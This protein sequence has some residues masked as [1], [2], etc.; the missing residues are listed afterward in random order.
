MFHTEQVHHSRRHKFHPRHL[1]E[2]ERVA[3]RHDQEVARASSRGEHGMHLLGE[4]GRW[5]SHRRPRAIHTLPLA[6]KISPHA[7]GHHGSP[8]A[9]GVHPPKAMRAAGYTVHAGVITPPTQVSLLGDDNFLGKSWLKKL[10]KKVT[11]FIP[12]PLKKI[13]SFVN[14]L[15]SPLSPIGLMS[16]MV[17]KEKKTAK[18]KAAKKAAAAAYNAPY[19]AIE[20]AK[21]AQLEQIKQ[22]QAQGASDAAVLA[23]QHQAQVDAQAAID[24]QTQADAQAQQQADFL[25]QQQQAALQAQQTTVSTPEAPYIP[26]APTPT[27]LPPSTASMYAPS[28]MAPAMQYGPQAQLPPMQQTYASQAPMATEEGGEGYAPPPQQVYDEI[29]QQMP[30]E[31]PGEEQQ[32]TEFPSEEESSDIMS[33]EDLTPEEGQIE[34]LGA[35]SPGVMTPLLLVGVGVA[36]YYFLGK[37]RR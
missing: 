33:T 26:Y 35:I 27:M 25:R 3:R 7:R 20:A 15:K 24:A 16:T 2:A 1:T 14:P 11:S 17:T 30:S 5:G 13:I 10:R 37:K 4:M 36:A 19:A 23:A 32:V 21:Q 31:L 28:P 6:I 9:P 22:Q 18:K 34:G 12:K 29:D 8:F